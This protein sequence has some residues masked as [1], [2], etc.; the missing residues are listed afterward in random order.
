MRYVCTHICSLD[1][2][3]LMLVCRFKL[4]FFI[5]KYVHTYVH[6]GDLIFEY[7]L[8]PNSVQLAGH[9]YSGQYILLVERHTSLVL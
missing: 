7:A 5:D 3:A 9:K 1:F 6:S 4:V 2:I 8:R